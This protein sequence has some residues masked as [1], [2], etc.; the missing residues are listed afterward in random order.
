MAAI[1][2]LSAALWCPRANALT[3]KEILLLHR[4][5]V[6]A[7]IIIE[8]IRRSGRRPRLSPSDVERLKKAKVSSRVIEFLLRGRVSKAGP[9]T[10]RQKA[11]AVFRR[12][13]EKRRAERAQKEA[14][15]RRR[16]AE[17]LRREAEKLKIEARK[18]AAAAAAART[19]AAEVRGRVVTM[20]RS[21]FRSHELGQYGK[22]ATMFFDFLHS[23]L[24]PPNSHR[25]VDG[26]FGLA[27]TL[28][29]AGLIQAAI[30]H[31]VE[32]LRRGP[33]TRRFNPAFVLL[34]KA[35]SRIDYSHPILALLGSFEKELH[36]RPSRW[37][38]AYHFLMGEF[39]ER[40]DQTGKALKHYLKVGRSSPRYAAAR[41][42]AALLSVREKRPRTALN[43]FR[44]ALGAARK[45]RQRETTDLAN[46]ALA[47]LAYEVG[48]WRAAAHHYGKIPR[49]S[50]LFWRAQ[51][52]LAWSQV[53]A[54]RYHKALGTLHGLHAPTMKNE[55]VPE[56]FVLEA[57]VY[58]NLCR[59][60]DGKK[61]VK[62]FK[63]RYQPLAVLVKRLL[64]QKHSAAALYKKVMAVAR[65]SKDANRRLKS[66]LLDSVEVYRAVATTAQVR[67]ELHKARRILSGKVFRSVRS[68][69]KRRYKALTEKAGLV[70]RRRLNELTGEL[71]ALEVK[72]TEISLEIELAEKMLL[73]AETT[74][75]RKG[76]LKRRREAKRRLRKLRLRTGQVTWPFEG[77][78]WLD[79]VGNYQSRLKS[80]C[81][82]AGATKP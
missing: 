31:L 4:T 77:E 57:A 79:E 73:E 66:A 16:E 21:G 61:A 35:V 25:Y 51:Y 65:G 80:V 78:Y 45:S 44:E 82:K 23:G 10:E 33:S 26:E 68:D 46:L 24:T 7:D 9:T 30:P 52:E 32:V 74:R 60:R 5:G 53:M 18:M 70:I 12:M 8:N 43:Y 49:T 59:Y 48:S 22:A 62:A 38:S 6:S 75:L 39:R 14:E 64:T 58:L 47:R 19:R 40:Y 67:S 72:A 41:Y 15:A 37:K 11:A 28:Y 63:S 42:H 55:H 71:E 3:L 56:R 2:V 20:L 13:E 69:L 34:H 54:Q 27:K 17:R 76:Q 1:L 29:K 36:A 50:K 81:R